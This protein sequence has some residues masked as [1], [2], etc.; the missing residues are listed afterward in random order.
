MS[1][2]LLPYDAEVEYLESTGTQWTKTDFTPNQNS[3]ID[4]EF[5]NTNT[6]TTIANLWLTGCFYTSDNTGPFGVRITR[7]D[8]GIFCAAPSSIN[9]YGSN[10]GRKFTGVFSDKKWS[11]ANVA[12][13]M[14]SDFECRAP[15]CLFGINWGIIAH[16]YDSIGG[17]V[18][19][20]I[21]RFRA[22]DNGVLVRDFIS[23]RFTNEQG[24]SEG[25][26]YDRVSGEL[27]GN[28]GTGSFIIGP[29]KH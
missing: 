20:R 9:Y 22:W 3:R 18:I 27:F 2:K 24:V 25:A 28:Q 8:F 29:D 16:Q 21:Y 15:L 10:V 26:M 19:A 1:G 23:V 7:S 17:L 12:S 11:I 6:D 5:E 4:I 13:G 14:S